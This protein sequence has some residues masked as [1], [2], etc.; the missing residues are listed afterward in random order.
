MEGTE[1]KYSKTHISEFAEYVGLG[2]YLTSQ[3]GFYEYYPKKKKQIWMEQVF[4][5]KSEALQFSFVG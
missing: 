5:K 4:T 3:Y 2:T 1:I